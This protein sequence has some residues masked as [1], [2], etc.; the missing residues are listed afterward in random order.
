MVV[1]SI[2]QRNIALC[3]LLKR[4]HKPELSEVG[5]RTSTLG[6]AANLYTASYI[7]FV[8]TQQSGRAF[9][10]IASNDQNLL[11]KAPAETRLSAMSPRISFMRSF[12]RRLK[13]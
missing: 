6:H 7:H 1:V 5:R 9:S 2:A 13:L 8:W 11:T 3:D 12:E 4:P 10:N